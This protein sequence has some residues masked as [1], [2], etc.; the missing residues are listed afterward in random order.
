MKA[1]AKV[2]E[3]Q[4]NKKNYSYYNNALQGSDIDLLQ[5]FSVKDPSQQQWQKA[6]TKD[7]DIK[8]IRM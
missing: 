8:A 4:K 3:K 7:K 6:P 5:L 2:I 1:K